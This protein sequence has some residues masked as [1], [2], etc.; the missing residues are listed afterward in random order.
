[1]ELINS[2][3]E[4]TRIESNRMK[5]NRIEA[6]VDLEKRENPRAFSVQRGILHRRLSHRRRYKGAV[7]L[8]GG[9]G[10]GRHWIIH[11]EERET[12]YM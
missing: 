7:L 3:Q 2:I 1:M 10:F 6:G 5:S 9:G 8:R 4:L 11:I 12:S